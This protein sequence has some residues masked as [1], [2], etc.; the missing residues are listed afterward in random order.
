MDRR[1]GVAFAGIPATSLSI[2]IGIKSAIRASLQRSGEGGP[3]GARL[4]NEK[5][6]KAID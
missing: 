2:A 4:K 3:T 1:T 6:N 5:K